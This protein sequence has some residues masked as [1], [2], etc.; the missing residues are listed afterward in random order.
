MIRLT[1]SA[2]LHLF[3]HVWRGNGAPGIK[4]TQWE[5]HTCIVWDCLTSGTWNYG[6]R[7]L[8][9]LVGRRHLRSESSQWEGRRRR[10]PGGWAASLSL[11]ARFWVCPRMICERGPAGQS[12]ILELIT[13][14]LRQTHYDHHTHLTHSTLDTYVTQS[15]STYFKTPAIKK[16]VTHARLVATPLIQQD[17]LLRWPQLQ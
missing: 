15:G 13:T 14:T 3:L 8:P 6:S 1:F 7:Q 4:L 16:L 9:H 11:S 5:L 12:A 17:T 2:H 10:P